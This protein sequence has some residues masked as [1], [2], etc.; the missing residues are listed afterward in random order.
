MNIL[1]LF[2]SLPNL[3]ENGVFTDLIKEFSNQGHNVKVA[4]PMI[5]KS[6]LGVNKEEGIDVLRFK[7]DPLTN[8]KSN[9]QKG[10]AYMK[11]IYQYNNA[12]KKYFGNE[13]F[14][15]IIGHSLPA[16]IGIIVSSLKRKYKAK[17]YLLLC[18]YVWQDSVSLGFFKKGGILHKYY[19]WMENKTVE[20]ADF[21]GCP[22]QGNVD[23]ALKYH[24][25]AINKNIHIIH[26]SQVPIRLKEP[27]IDIK[28]KFNLTGK[29]VVI[30]GGNMSIAQKISN[31][32]DLAESCLDYKDII[33]LLLGKGNNIDSVK[34][35]IERRNLKNITFLDF[36]PKDEYLQL[37]SICD[38]GLVSLNE[39]MVVPNIPSKTLSYFSL[40]IPVVASIDI[41]TDYGKYLEF[42]GAGLWS[43]A[44]DN[45]KFKENLLKLYNSPKL[46]AQMAQNG[47][48]FFLNNMV[49]E[50]AYK[51]IINQ[52]SNVINEPK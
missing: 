24:P 1:F 34:E 26:Y 14:D 38:V 25:S 16:E 52:I 41:N 30:Y 32:L 35:D 8:N 47:Y 40:S 12:I 22:S 15:L 3:S 42:A 7:T 43:Y 48:H 27:E 46:K 5:N 10:I 44:G 13:Q 20:A 33:F 50:I 21:I 36:M 45:K 29:F 6:I 31:V 49:P 39:K 19:Q 28:D 2:I 23:F 17:F 4:T 51:T 11:L 18:E 9:I 37:L